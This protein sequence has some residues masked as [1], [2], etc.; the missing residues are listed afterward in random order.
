[1]TRAL[2]VTGASGYIGRALVPLARSQGWQ[3]VALGRRPA[4][5]ADDFR[6]ADLGEPL[7]ADLLNGLDAV[8]HLAANTT[9]TALPDGA[10]LAFATAL[11]RACADRGVPLV[12]VSS[13]AASPDA[14]SRY[15]RTKFEI[16]SAV[17]PLGAM[18][19][20]PGQVIGGREAGLFGM[21]VSLVRALPVLPMLLPR[22]R[23]Q[24][25]HVDDLALAILAA[26]S[27]P[28]LAG[29]CISVAGAPVA[30][31][32][33]LMLI[34]HDRLHRRRVRFPV[35]VGLL[36]TALWAAGRIFG[37]RLSPER[38]DSLTSL[39][40]LD[41]R[42]DLR[43]LGIELRPLAQALDRRSRMRRVMLHEATTLSWATVARRPGSSLLRRYARLLPALGVHTPLALP[44][45][46]RMSPVALA[47][48]DTPATR[49]SSVTGDLSWRMDVVAKLAEAEPH[50]ADAY[51][52]RA[53]QAGLLRAAF[54]LGRAVLR[55]LQIRAFAP[56]ARWASR[57]RA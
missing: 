13:Q 20:R 22:P 5:A 14:P 2:G 9:G 7:P 24:P 54:D 48:L 37:P 57:G 8:I 1:M 4:P 42:D 30:F 18:V 40:Q 47:S 55:E 27:K 12:V 33:L 53:G 46:V 43:R 51:L 49:R 52:P 6:P 50:W 41:A 23:V 16:E 34:A 25:V 26:L 28:E 36:R 10:E 29:T 35:P 56:W 15:G 39:P 3:V 38:L 45:A 44:P 21:L 11:A 17:Q 31:D 32:D 19:V